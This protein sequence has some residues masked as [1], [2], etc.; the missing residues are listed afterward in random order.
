MRALIREPLVHFFALGGLIFALYATVNDAG[1]PQTDRIEITAADTA[2]IERQF[3]AAWNRPPT[4]Q[5]FEALLARHIDQELLVRE[6][7]ALGLDRN[8]R[9]V[10]QRLEQKMRFLIE[11]R[12]ALVEPSDAELQEYLNRNAEDFRRAQRLSFEQFLLP[13][14]T[15]ESGIE[16][17]LADL[18]E[19]N[20]PEA[21]PSILP[22][23]LS[24]ASPST[25]DATFGKGF[26]DAVNELE[27]GLWQGG[28]TGGYG[29]HLVRI[30]DRSPGRLPPLAEIRDEVLQDWRHSR[31]EAHVE[32]TLQALRDRYDVIVPIRE[33]AR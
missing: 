5:E 4:E 19:G 33:A 11:G 7:T 17:A 6:A 12:A 14:G 10:R 13:D 22:S 27:V 2:L 1:P 16:A 24:D 8:D 18:R 21:I 20:T 28:V 9:V 32:E 29:T 3:K 23:A 25:V 31:S 26:F 30:T 15:S